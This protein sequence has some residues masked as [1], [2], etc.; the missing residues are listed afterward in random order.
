MTG[1]APSTDALAIAARGRPRFLVRFRR[2]DQ[3]V[4]EDV[5][6]RRRK[7]DLLMRAD[8]AVGG[9]HRV[10]QHE[11]GDAGFR[12]GRRPLE[13]ALGLGIQAQVPAVS[14]HLGSSTHPALPRPLRP[15]K[16]A[17]SA[18]IS[19]AGAKNLR[20]PQACCDPRKFLQMKLESGRARPGADRGCCRSRR[21]AERRR[22][23]RCR[24]AASRAAAG[25]R[26][27]AGRRSGKCGRRRSPSSCRSSGYWSDRALRP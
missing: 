15:D 2:V 1:E 12:I 18:Y 13:L 11:I 10:R 16:D 20:P 25:C 23:R 8:D 7:G 14:F 27:A 22:R 6:V 9:R 24:A 21:R 26:P 19:S 17:N 5:P 3:R 4:E